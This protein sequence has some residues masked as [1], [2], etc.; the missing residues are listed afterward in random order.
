MVY[1]ECCDQCETNCYNTPTPTP[2]HGG[3]GTWIGTTTVTSYTTITPGLEMTTTSNGVVIV[4]TSAAAESTTT[5]PSIVYVTS[6]DSMGQEG[7]M[8][9]LWS[10]GMWLAFVA[11]V[12]ILL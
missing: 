5:G 3:G 9:N 12:M 1:W 7:G 4:Y 6:N 11:T 10:Y 2:T 8:P